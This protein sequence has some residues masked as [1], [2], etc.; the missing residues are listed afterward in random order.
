MHC[1]C[2]LL[3]AL[4]RLEVV[5]AALACDLALELFEP[6]ERHSGSIG[7][8]MAGRGSGNQPREEQEGCAFAY[9]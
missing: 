9:S 1:L 4:E 8:V 7:T 3:F 2:L 6:V 5:E